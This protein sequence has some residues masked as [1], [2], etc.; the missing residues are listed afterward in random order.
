MNKK[1]AII[2]PT[3]KPQTYLKR[4][5][6]S[7]EMQTLP[8][9]KFCVYIALNGDRYPYEN[10][11]LPSLK[12]YS[13]NSKY[14]YIKESGVSNA[15]NK[16]INYSKEEF[17]TFIDDDDLVS[18]NYLSNLLEVSTQEYVG[19]AKVYNFRKSINILTSHSIGRLYEKL[20]PSE[21]SK[22]NT[23]KYYSPICAKL[24][25]R[26]IIGD[27]RFDTHL[28]NGE[29]SLF[30]ATIS[31]NI[32]KLCKPCNE[33]CYYVYERPNSASRRKTLFSYRLKNSAYVIREC[34]KLLMLPGYN[35]LFILTRILATLK[36]LMMGLN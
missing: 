11:I 23:R 33:A 22:L 15:R 10:E 8:K 21:T 13:F 3:H 16:L 24:I 35:K 14:I 19:I 6:D 30:M 18:P 17:I 32:K 7:L 25:H 27:T 9:E 26:N 28:K 1:I 20:S 29:D 2:I 34:F 31:K 5:L 36:K 12:L 4:C